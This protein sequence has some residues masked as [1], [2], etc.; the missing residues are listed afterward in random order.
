MLADVLFGGIHAVT[1]LIVLT[2]AGNL[3]CV[4]DVG[5]VVVVALHDVCT[6]VVGFYYV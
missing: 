4:H 1:E 6:N 3:F 5:V 2:G